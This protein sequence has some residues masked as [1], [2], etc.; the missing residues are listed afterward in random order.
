M[1]ISIRVDPVTGIA[2]ATCAGIVGF[3]EA[4]EGTAA[5]WS[6]PGWADSLAVWDVREA[7]T[8]FSPADAREFAQFVLQ[9]Q[10]A[11]PPSKVAFVAGRDADFGMARMF[12]VFREDE[13]TAFRVFRDFDEAIVWL[14]SS[15]AGAA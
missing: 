9:N 6:T 7:Q 2:V 10:P 14:Q 5:L 8:D 15:R 13:R 4:K 3:G 11:A 12:E 1:P